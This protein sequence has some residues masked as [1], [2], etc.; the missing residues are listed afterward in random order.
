MTTPPPLPPPGLGVVHMWRA[1]LTGQVVEPRERHAATCATTSYSPSCLAANI[2]GLEKKVLRIFS[3]AW[4]GGESFRW[5]LIH[6]SRSRADW[7]Y[8]WLMSSSL[9][10][11]LW[12]LPAVSGSGDGGGGGAG[13]VTGWGGGSGLLYWPAAVST[14]PLAAFPPPRSFRA[15]SRESNTR[16]MVGRVESSK[17]CFHPCRTFWPNNSWENI[18]LL[19]SCFNQRQEMCL[20]GFVS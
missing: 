18:N 13:N 16:L 1:Q 14:G 17:K 6:L 19:S 3:F 15:R 7:T 10:M 20:R 8:R 9:V 2:D 5:P 11:S 4:G 12:M